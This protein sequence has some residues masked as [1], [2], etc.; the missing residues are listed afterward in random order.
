MA[1]PPV[2]N[3]LW[4]YGPEGLVGTLHNTDPLSFSYRGE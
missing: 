3:A 2:Q 1:K 4:V